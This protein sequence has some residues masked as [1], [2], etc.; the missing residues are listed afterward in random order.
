MHPR[1]GMDDMD[2]GDCTV[3]LDESPRFIPH[4]PFSAANSTAK[5]VAV[6][7][8]RV[9]RRGGL[10]I[11]VDPRHLWVVHVLEPPM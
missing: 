5:S 1:S 8:S 4:Q 2:P 10:H 6:D 9:G 11:S 3:L 7:M